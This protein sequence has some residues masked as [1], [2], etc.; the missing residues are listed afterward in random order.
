VK[1]NV[2]AV[3]ASRKAY[4]WLAAS[5]HILI[6]VALG[7][8]A[9]DRG[10][11]IVAVTDTAGT[12]ER[13]GELASTSRVCQTFVAQHEGL[14]QVYVKLDNYDRQNTGSFVLHLRTKP[15]D[16]Q[17]L[18]TLIHD[19]AQVEKEAYHLFEYPPIHDSAGRS[20]CF[21]LEAPDAQL[22]NSITAIGTLENL[23]TDGTAVFREM[24]G[25]GIG[26][27]DLDFRLGYDLS[28]TGKLAVF[29]RRMPAYKPFIFGAGWF[30]SLLAVV[31][32]ALIYLTLV[33]S[34]PRSVPRH[35]DPESAE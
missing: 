12:R 32:L 30:Y 34:V 6:I 15:D 4:R 28:L 19:A 24:W 17:D 26:V 10:P 31:Y 18:R 33:L 16:V 14:S 27:R 29:A 9:L 11:L 25:Q 3:W 21:C 1:E 20:Y 22:D 7:A 13:I 2:R 8:A 5:A 23:Y 35:E